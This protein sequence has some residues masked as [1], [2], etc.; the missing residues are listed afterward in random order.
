MRGAWWHAFVC[1]FVGLVSLL[2]C[3]KR[4]WRL[5]V[6]LLI[7]LLSIDSLLL[8]SR[9]FKAESVKEI[10]APHTV[11]DQLAQKQ[12]VERVAFV[13]QNGYIITGWR[14]MAYIEISAF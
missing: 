4:R 14:W 6:C 11:L 2:L 12:G 8:T 7:G 5:A 13:D 9:Y 3:V 10:S 1:A